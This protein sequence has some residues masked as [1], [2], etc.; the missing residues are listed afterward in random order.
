MFYLLATCAQAPVPLRLVTR[1]LQAQ[2]DNEE[3]WGVEDVC[4]CMLLSPVE[5]VGGVKTLSVHQV[6]RSVLKD[7][8][9]RDTS[10]SA[11]KTDGLYCL[12]VYKGKDVQCILCCSNTFGYATL[13]RC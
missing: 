1:V 10:T 3:L 7:L 6:T 11:G 8:L 2:Q 4:N 5:L 12:N 9:L 13:G